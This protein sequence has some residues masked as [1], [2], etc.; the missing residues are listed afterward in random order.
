MCHNLQR[1]LG[2]GTGD[3]DGAVGEDA[4]GTL[5]TTLSEDANGT[6]NGTL[7]GDANSTSMETLATLIH[8]DIKTSGHLDAMDLEMASQALAMDQV[9]ASTQDSGCT[10]PQNEVHSPPQNQLI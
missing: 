1:D 6:F 9:Q 10:R 2:T 4:N 8:E 7:G 5:N 3:T